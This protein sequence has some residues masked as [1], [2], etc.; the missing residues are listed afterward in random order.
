MVNVKRA[1]RA[2]IAKRASAIKKWAV[3]IARMES[4][5]MEKRARIARIA[6]N[7]NCSFFSQLLINLR[8]RGA[9]AQ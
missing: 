6:A 7:T 1:K 5:R 9:A 3:E 8:G 4:V 2:R